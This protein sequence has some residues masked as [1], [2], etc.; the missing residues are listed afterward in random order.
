MMILGIGSTL[1]K[2]KTFVYVVA[3]YFSNA[4][5]DCF[6]TCEF[7]NLGFTPAPTNE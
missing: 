5:I 6:V 4:E 2:L 7:N 1:L 3:R